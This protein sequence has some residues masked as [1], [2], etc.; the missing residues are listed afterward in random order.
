MEHLIKLSMKKIPDP[1]EIDN[2]LCNLFSNKINVNF[3][4]KIMYKVFQNIGNDIT[5]YFDFDFYLTSEK[6]I[7][8][9]YDNFTLE[10]DI[11][12]YIVGIHRS[13][14]I[15]LSTK[16]K[17][18]KEHSDIYC[19]ELINDVINNIKLRNYAGVYFRKYPILQGENFIYFSLPYDLFAIST[20]MNDI[21]VKEFYRHTHLENLYFQIT[22]KGLAALSL[23]EN[24]FLDSAYSICRGIIEIY[25]KMLMLLN[26][27]SVI[28]KCSKYSTFEIQYSCSQ[29]Y[30][31]EFV[32]LFSRSKCKSNKSNYLH[33]GWVDEIPNYH[34]KVTKSP[35]SI[36]GLL[37]YLK[38]IYK[39]TDECF[40]Q[41]LEML[42]KMCHGYIHGGVAGSKYPILHYFEISIMLYYTLTHTYRI[43]CESFKVDPNIEDI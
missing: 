34:N 32:E 22:N 11:C 3:L 1:N 16:E 39:L 35:Y 36:Q 43:V 19:E 27:P 23:L 25:I 13:N 38:S 18:E 41:N 7:S 9:L 12:C 4:M 14:S 37:T 10:Y 40:F 2:V 26:C 20:R 33:F 15:F 5:R 8:G 28:E 31:D 17:K 30:P 29:Q 6:I 21:L 24:N 42:Y